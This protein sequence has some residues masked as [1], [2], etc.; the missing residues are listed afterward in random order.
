MATTSGTNR[1]TSRF[2][3]AFSTDFYRSMGAGLTVSSIGMGTYLGE[4]DDEE[5][6]R[7]TTAIAEGVRHGLNLVDTA[8]NYR[9]QRSERAVGRALH[10]ALDDGI[11][12]RDE[13]VVC[14]KGGFIPLDG[15]PPSSRD[16]YDRFLREHYFDRGVMSPGDVVAGGHCL[17]P[18]FLSDQIER[19]LRNLGL[20][21]IDVYYLHN[22]EHQATSL[23]S[24]RFRAI[25]TEAFRILEV[26]AQL[27][28]I[29]VY[30]C[31]TWDG[32][33]VGPA[34][35]GHLSLEEFVR[36]AREVGGDGH[37]FRVVQLPLNLAMNE[38]IR[39]P[40]QK[41]GATAVPLL[42]A[43]TELGVTVIGSASLMQ[44]QLTKGLPAELASAFPGLRTD[45]QRALAF[46]RSL[47]IASALVGMRSIA[48][49]RENL[50]AGSPATAA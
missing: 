33:R 1:Y 45:A 23:D 7:Y 37:H 15:Q 12:A 8:V 5:D 36:I 17:T 41:I 13:V 32:F 21:Q 9:C 38:A 40:T 29:G 43:A 20:A 18:G 42:Q 44:A 46:A 14:T 2:R 16:D 35:R 25:L 47:P 22:P 28:R 30:G 26:E 3:S 31:A 48:H 34:R 6:E 10:R 11:I 19:S 27:G 4:C 39:S 49:I 24:N 50:G